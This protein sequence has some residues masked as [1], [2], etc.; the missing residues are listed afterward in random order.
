MKNDVLVT[1]MI[2]EAALAYLR[3]HTHVDLNA[4]DRNLTPGE[5]RTRLR[6]KHGVLAM[7]TDRLDR[8]ALESAP[9]L[10]VIS[11]CA[12]GSNN[13]DLEYAR[14]RNMV[15]ANTPEA[16]KQAVADLAWA[17][18]LACARRIPEADRE[19]RRGRFKGWAPLY[20]LGRGV[21]GKTLG[22]LGMGRIGRE[23]ASRARGFKMP[24]I[25]HNRSGGHP[26]QDRPL[27]ARWVPFETLV[28]TSDYLVLLAPLTT[29]THHLFSEKEFR[30]MKKEAFLINLSRG[31]V[32]DEAALV[33]A[34][35][36]GWIAG[37]GL[38][39][40]EFEPDVHKGLLDLPNAVLLP[41][42][43]SATVETRSQMAMEAARNLVAALEGR[44]PLSTA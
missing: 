4:R 1:R 7:L 21:H 28:R 16:L 31:P 8:A 23:V 34:L 29:A 2:P 26:R 36:Q 43:G 6:G 39:V 32:V 10:R 30:A 5:L 19:V 18:I 37:A 3:K 27:N 17:L 33:R 22:I 9:Y 15:V 13:V 35:R 14:T 44:R 25:Y 24:V 12:G 11:L 38:D 41:H 42:I 20:L 40:Y